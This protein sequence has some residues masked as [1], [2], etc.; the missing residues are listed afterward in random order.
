[1][2]INDDAV[3]EYVEINGEQVPKIV[4][5]AEITITHT[6]TGKEY[7][8]EKEAQEDIDNPATTTAIHHIRRDVLVKVALHKILENAIGKV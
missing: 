5:P 1:M 8:S 2:P 4:V 7:G 6:E 3:I